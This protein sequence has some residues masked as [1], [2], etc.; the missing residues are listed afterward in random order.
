MSDFG[1]S[2]SSGEQRLLEVTSAA[3]V[4]RERSLD[5]ETLDELR[6]I[7][8]EVQDRKNSRR[9]YLFS[10]LFPYFSVAAGSAAILFFV[11]WWPNPAVNIDSRTELMV[12]GDWL[13][14]EDMDI[15]MIEDME[16]YQWLAEELD[17]HS[18]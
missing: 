9:T 7:R 18:S 11:L 4:R 15:E 6:R 5:T 13:L 14:E 17:G 1:K 3:V 12:S 8:A 2:S 16:F 10:S